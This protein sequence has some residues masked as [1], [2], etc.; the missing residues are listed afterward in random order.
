MVGVPCV[1][2]ESPV[3]SLEGRNSV[4]RGLDLRDRVRGV[5]LWLVESLGLVESR[6]GALARPASTC[7]HIHT[8]TQQGS[9]SGIVGLGWARGKGEG[10]GGLPSPQARVCTSTHPHTHTHSHR[11]T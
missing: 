6:R 4:G 3:R 2:S 9:G 7:V 1:H 11:H 8:S 10:E 5:E